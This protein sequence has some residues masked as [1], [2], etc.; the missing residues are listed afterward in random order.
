MD[1][2]IVRAIRAPIPVYVELVIDLELTGVWFGLWFVNATSVEA[3][4]AKISEFVDVEP[5]DTIILEAREALKSCVDFGIG[6]I[7]V[8]IE[9]TFSINSGVICWV[10][11]DP[12]ERWLWP[13]I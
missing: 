9:A 7:Y 5:K 10:E 1:K 6:G 3:V 11:Q 12:R 4:V 13:L 2:R 8:P